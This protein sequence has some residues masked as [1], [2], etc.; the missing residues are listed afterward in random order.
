VA[1]AVLIGFSRLPSPS[2]TS[3][4]P[5]SFQAQQFVLVNGSG[6]ALAT[7]GAGPHGG[8]VLTFFDSQGKRVIGVGAFDGN[9]GDGLALYDGN[10][11]VPSATSSYRGSFGISDSGVGGN[12]ADHDGIIRLGWGI[13]TGGTPGFATYDQNGVIRTGS[14]NSPG[15]A[16][17][18]VYDSGGAA[19]SGVD[20]NENEGTPHAGFFA[21]DANGINRAFLGAALDGSNT[22]LGLSDAAGVY[23]AEDYVT[24]DGSFSGSFV[25][26]VN[27]LDRVLSYQQGAA[28]GVATWDSTGTL[29]PG[30]SPDGFLP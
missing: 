25:R 15:F 19:R 8:A 18:V 26:D 11:F 29:V 9:N 28:Q 1:F 5:K 3:A 14:G 24:G 27:N 30:I 16:G 4:A 2:A 12:V 22:D 17:H 13:Q 20:V 6:S 21:N 7:L 23:E 10:S